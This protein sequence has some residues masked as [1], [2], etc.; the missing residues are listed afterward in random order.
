MTHPEKDCYF[1]KKRAASCS[2][3]VQLGS[4]EPKM[5]KYL[6]HMTKS[7]TFPDPRDHC[8]KKVYTRV[9]YNS[10]FSSKTITYPSPKANGKLVLCKDAAGEVCNDQG[11]ID[12][13][14]PSSKVKYQK[15]ERKQ[16]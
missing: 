11:T 16:A 10:N 14:R 8:T 9:F 7:T 3:K 15:S 12:Y 5:G 6:N 1:A 13:G 4:I 2:V